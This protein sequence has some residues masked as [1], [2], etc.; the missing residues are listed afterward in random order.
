MQLNLK[1]TVEEYVCTEKRA[2][3]TKESKPTW[4]TQTN[5]IIYKANCETNQKEF[6][7][8]LSVFSAIFFFFCK[9]VFYI[10]VGYHNHISDRITN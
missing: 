5:A 3:M 8:C 10:L 6:A 7:F 2:V 1:C 4:T 9:F